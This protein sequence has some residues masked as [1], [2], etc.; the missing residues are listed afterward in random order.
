[1]FNSSID[2]LVPLPFFRNVPA[3]PELNLYADIM[4]DA[5]RLVR[6]EGLVVKTKAADVRAAH[7]WIMAGDIGLVTFDACCGWL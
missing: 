3:R 2:P 5:V 1:M 7:Y 4:F 6:G